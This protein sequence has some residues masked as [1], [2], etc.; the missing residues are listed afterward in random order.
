MRAPLVADLEAVLRRHGLDRERISLR[1]T[2]CPNGCA[3]SYGGDI[4]LVGRVPG[5]YAV[6]VGGD[7]AGTRLSF[8][9]LERVPQDRVAD[10]AGAAAGGLRGTAAAGRG[11]RGFLPPA[12]AGGGAC[13]GRGGAGQRRLT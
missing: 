1:I 5:A 11:V 6:F 9:L 13:S 8:K 7:F 2:G 10:R 12:G 4:G 3:R